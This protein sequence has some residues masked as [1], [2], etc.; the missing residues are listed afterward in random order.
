VKVLVLTPYLPH[1]RVGHGGGTA[2]RDLVTWLA[3]KHEVMVL[4]LVRPGEEDLLGEVAELGAQVKGLPFLDRAASG[5]TRLDF[6]ARRLAAFFRSLSSGYPLYVEKYADDKLARL[7]SAAVA[8]FQPDAIQIEYLQMSPYCRDL[9]QLRDAAGR[10][11]PRLILNSHELGSLPRERRAARAGNPLSR[12]LALREAAAW[13]KLQVDASSWADTTLC[14]TPEDHEL[15]AAMGGHN[16]ATMPLGMDLSALQVDWHPGA[17]DG[18]ETHL[19]VGS[20][21]H[22]PNVL[23]AELLVDQIWPRVLAERPDAHLVLAGRGSEEFLATR[24]PND[25]WAKRRLEALGFV[26]DLTP[27]FRNCRLFVAPL[28]EGGGIKIKILEAMARGVPVVTT[29]VGAEG[30]TRSAD[31]AITISPC[32]DSFAAAIVRDAADLPGCRQRATVARQLMANHF[33]WDAI[34][35]RLTKLYGNLP[36]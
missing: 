26:D 16:L 20:F 36:Q 2:V 8:D 28:P 11:T 13:R 31:G 15:Y 22:R 27:H 3:R 19:F 10:S 12:W 33:S 6:Y 35:D 17:V 4:S 23:A 21:G 29:P 24:I 7:I 30:I 18:R 34:T 14:V 32:D 5:T 25:Q 1:R 9:R